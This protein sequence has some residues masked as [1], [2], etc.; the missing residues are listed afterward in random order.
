[1]HLIKYL[2]IRKVSAFKSATA[3]IINV[4]CHFEQ[5]TQQ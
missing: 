1:L 3:L 5:S 2:A 4:I